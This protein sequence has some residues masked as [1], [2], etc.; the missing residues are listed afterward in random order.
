MVAPWEA[1][2]ASFS[3][4]RHRGAALHPGDDDGL[5]HGGQSILGVQGRRSAA[6]A[7]N[8]G[9]VIV[10]D[11]VRIQCIHL[12]PDGTVQAGVAGV[13][14]DGGLPGRFHLPH[15]VQ[16]L[17]QRHPGAVVD[18]TAWL[19]QPQQGR[20]DQTSGVDDAVGS[21]QQDGPPPGDQIRCAGSGI[22]KMYHSVT[23]SIDR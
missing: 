17:F 8:A 4:F 19:C 1:R 22:N 21:L 14:A 9:G 15:D 7:G 20:V 12:L 10:S 13:E 11:A 23:P 18:G 3:F 5:A 2:L 6:E 16:H